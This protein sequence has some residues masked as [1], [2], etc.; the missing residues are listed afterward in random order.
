MPGAN[1]LFQIARHFNTSIDYLLGLTDDPRPVNQILKEL[2]AE[3]VDAP[4]ELTLENLQ[5]RLD[6]LEASLK[7]QG[8]KI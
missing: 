7:A 3:K 6:K 4:K 2:S 1:K 5:A 8:I